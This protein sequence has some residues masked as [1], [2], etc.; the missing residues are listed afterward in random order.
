[1]TRL[2]LAAAEACD[3]SV[4][5]A[6]KLKVPLAVGVPVRTPLLAKVI[7]PGS[8]PADTLQLYPMPVPPAAVNVAEYDSLTVPP[9]RDVVVMDRGVEPED[10]EEPPPQLCRG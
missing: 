2:R 7:P 8:N 9:A 4:T 10:A 6:V 5:A 3:E 1:M